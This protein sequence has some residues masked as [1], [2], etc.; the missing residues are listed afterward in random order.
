M[1]NSFR[2]D[3]RMG[4]IFWFSYTVIECFKGIRGKNTTVHTVLTWSTVLFSN[5]KNGQSQ[6]KTKTI[7]LI[8]GFAGFYLVLP[9][10]N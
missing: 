5:V 1:H 7:S 8:E 9:S 4:Y 3:I 10:S 6:T 2:L